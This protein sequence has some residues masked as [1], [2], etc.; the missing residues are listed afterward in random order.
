MTQI[1]VNCP[2]RTYRRASSKSLNGDGDGDAG[3]GGDGLV[4]EVLCG[5]PPQEASNKTVISNATILMVRL[6]DSLPASDL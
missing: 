6:A 4:F 5:E 1:Y 2:F 3:G